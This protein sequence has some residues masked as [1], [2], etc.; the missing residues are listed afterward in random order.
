[1]NRGLLLL[2]CPQGRISCL[3]RHRAHYQVLQSL[4]LSAVCR[5]CYTSDT[6]LQPFLPE[7]TLWTSVSL[8][9]VFDRH[10]WWISNQFINSHTRNVLYVVTNDSWVWILAIC[11]RRWK[12]KGGWSPPEHSR[13]H[14][15]L[16]SHLL[17][18]LSTSFTFWTTR[19][20]GSRAGR[21]KKTP[22]PK[23]CQRGDKDDCIKNQSRLVKSC[24]RVGNYRATKG[25]HLDQEK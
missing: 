17:K 25:D 10:L 4:W 13:I 2:E 19:Q 15:S 6:P 12:F 8:I 5:G 23:H 16:H 22:V 21:L 7:R 20:L 14:L 18:S 9:Q 1:M 3:W 24:N 11:S